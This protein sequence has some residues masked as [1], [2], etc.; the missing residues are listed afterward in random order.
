VKAKAVVAAGA[1]GAVE[2]AGTVYM[3]GR[4]E[5]EKRGEMF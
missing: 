3:V 5:R 1:V 4:K 2:R